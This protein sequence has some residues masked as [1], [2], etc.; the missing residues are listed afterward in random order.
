MWSAASVVIFLLAALPYGRTLNHD[1]VAWDDDINVFENPLLPGIGDRQPGRLRAFWTAPYR[2][3][4]IPVTYTLWYAL[5]AG[6]GAPA[7]SESGNAPRPELKPGRLSRGQR[8]CF[9]GPTPC[10]CSGFW[11]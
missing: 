9:M 2:N 5:A 11:C 1:F 3:L 10:S 4:Y 7:R 6:P 8:F